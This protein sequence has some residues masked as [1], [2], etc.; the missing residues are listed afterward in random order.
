M[1]LADFKNLQKYNK[2]FLCDD[3]SFLENKNKDNAYIINIDKVA[4]KNLINKLKKESNI[5]LFSWGYFKRSYLTTLADLKAYNNLEIFYSKFKRRNNILIKIFTLIYGSKLFEIALKKKIIVQLRDYYEIKIIKKIL[6]FLSKKRIYESINNTDYFYIDKNLKNRNIKFFLN[7]KSINYKIILKFICF[8]LYFSLKQ[9][10]FINIKKI[11]FK[12]FFRIYGNGIGVGELG[13]LDWILKYEKLKNETNVFVL[14]DILEDK[15]KHKKALIKNNYQYI[16]SSNNQKN[17]ISIQE[18]LKN[19]IFF[20]PL[21]FFLS[22]YLGIFR[23]NYI[24]FFYEAWTSFFKWSNFVNWF[25]GRNYIV[26]HNYQINHIF[27]NIFLKKKNFNLVHYKHTSSEN[28][29]CYNTKNKYRNADQA[30]LFYD[31]EFHQT[32]QSIE[33]SEKNESFTK[34]KLIYG[35]TLLLEKKNLIFKKKQIVLFNSSFTDGHAANPVPAHQK[36]LYFIQKMANKYDYK[37]IFKSKKKIDLYENYNN[38]FYNLIKII[39]QN[40]KV[41]IIDYAI[42]LQDIILESD[43]SIHMPFASSCIISLFNK[44]KFFFYDSLSY[45]KKSYYSKFKDIK[46]ISNNIDL[47]FELI[48]FYSKMT[49]SEYEKYIYKCYFETFE[50][51]H[52]KEKIM[53]KNYL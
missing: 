30:F 29:F 47:N 25:N 9:K 16:Y 37:I 1:K 42:D 49:Q 31:F 50:K 10:I 36:F 13:N 12:N 28:I 34:K 41:K 5:F 17:K 14:E 39:R 52:Y 35:P 23:Q 6:S 11:Y 38:E 24:Y 27:R 53:I 51:D 8:P 32:K 18:L 3:L 15:T 43:L 33:M 45:Y 22:L 4:N 40:K 2:A 48:E 46:L 7:I 26:Y 20:F 19:I 44:K 21:G